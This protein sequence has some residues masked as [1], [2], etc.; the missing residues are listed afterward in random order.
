MWAGRLL[1]VLW[2]SNM[3][4][5]LNLSKIFISDSFIS[6]LMMLNKYL[7]TLLK[8]STLSSAPLFSFTD[9]KV[10]SKDT[11][12][13]SCILTKSILEGTDRTDFWYVHNLNCKDCIQGLSS[14]PRTF[15]SSKN[16][17][18]LSLAKRIFIRHTHIQPH[19][20]LEISLQ[21][22]KYSV[23]NFRSQLFLSIPPWL[24]GTAE[25]LEWMLRNM[26]YCQHSGACKVIFWKESGRKEHLYD[27]Y[28]WSLNFG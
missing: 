25:G 26:S 1:T 27:L 12:K 9:S 22:Y 10:K 17:V 6:N 2:I 14:Q 18:N 15:S 8:L 11:I 16:A 21:L 7:K 5:N 24:V 13:A 19:P 23:A 4:N 28:H 20:T 3:R